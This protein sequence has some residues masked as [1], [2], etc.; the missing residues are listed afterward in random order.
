MVERTVE[1]R[2]REE[3]FDLL[4]EIQRVLDHLEAEVKYRLL[5]VRRK[6]D[7]FERVAVSSRTKDC[8]SAV[9][10]LRRRQQGAIF[11]PDSVQPYSLA[12]LKD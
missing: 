6:L 1:D 9:E 3:Y 8:Q 5:P 7:K 2:L 11:Y 12:N 4:P 10:S